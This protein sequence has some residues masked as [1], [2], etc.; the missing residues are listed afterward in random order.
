MA[1][2]TTETQ[3]NLKINGESAT[4]TM[5]GM[6]KEVS[7]LRRELLAI[8]T[9]TQEFIDKA[10][11]LGEAENRLNGARDA[12]KQVRTQMSALGDDTRKANKDLLSLSPTGRILLDLSDNFN[13]VRSA[14]G[15]NITA[16]NLLKVALASTGIGALVI[17]LVSLFQYFTKSD[18]GAKKL[19]GAMKALSIITGQLTGF[20]IKL[21]EG[22]M[23]AFENPKQAMADLVNFITQNVM[24]RFK[25]LGVIIEGIIN[26][27]IKKIGDGFIQAGTG[28]ENATDKIINFANETGKAIAAAVEEG[29]RM[30]ELLDRIDEN[31]TKLI[32]SN[33]LAEEQISRLLLQSKDRTK[34]E[35]ERL[36]LLDRASAL[37]TQRLQGQISLAQQKLEVARFEAAQAAKNDVDADAAARKLAEAEANLINLRKDSID[38]QEKIS[39]RRNQ[40]LDAETA[41]KEAMAKAEEKARLDAEKAELEYLR[42]LTDLR[43]ANIQDEEERKRVQIDINFK[44][45]LEDAALKNQL[46][47][48]MELELIRQREQAK[49][50]LEKQLA[51]QKREEVAAKL[52]ITQAE[53]VQAIENL[54]LSEQE[55]EDRIYEVNRLG[56]ENRLTLIKDQYG[57]QSIE[58][59]KAA[60]EIEKLDT[61]HYKKRDDIAKRSLDFNQRIEQQK[62]G[63][64]SQTFGGI[65]D[66]L[67]QDEANRAQNAGMI[68]AFSAAEI[69][70]LGIKEVAGIWSNANINALNALIPGW[71]PAFATVQTGMSIA[72]TTLGLSN[73]ARQQ[74]AKGGMVSTRGGVV[75]EGQYHTNGGIHLIDG[76]TGGHLGE[77]ERDE[78]LMVLSRDFTAA[79]RPI[80]DMMLD[81][82]AYNRPLNFSRKMES[83]GML[84]VEAAAAAGSPAA[85]GV[86]E[87]STAMLSQLMQ[88]NQNFARFPTVIRAVVDYEQNNAV[89]LMARSIQEEANA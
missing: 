83:G 60:L 1:G 58:A 23:K 64:M 43:V 57:E 82:S 12:A 76:A 84:E 39:N 54:V 21:G 31:E 56:L 78:Y 40:L 66:L 26:L 19:D 53:Q 88:L 48:E 86:N 38:L 75:T 51:D 27:D 30:A 70:T 62:F 49:A 4:N 36:V 80:L 16:T 7:A 34:S 13:T 42:R 79:N 63:L 32:R 20:M 72:R 22:I 17:A 25:A 89:D 81:A 85:A 55:K 6:Q 18:E 71:G 61:D 69:V 2:N 11:E 46:T 3:V 73:L 5:K 9:D 52:E 33:A 29:N 28:I 74:F 68:K 77:M 45:A 41:K 59:R 15:A 65:A 50:D 14:I 67:K 37:E 87:T 47:T 44:R 8:P 24:N 10:K 35:A